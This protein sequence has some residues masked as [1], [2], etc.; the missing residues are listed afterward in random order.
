MTRTLLVTLGLL[1]FTFVGCSSLPVREDDTLAA[2]R[3]ELTKLVE[4]GELTN[5][6]AVKF[7]GIASLEVER[8]A[9]QRAEQSQGTPAVE[10]RGTVNRP[11]VGHIL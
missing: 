7:Y 11:S 9:A 2:Y 1:A 4:T 3:L 5:D 6:D 8:R 10:S